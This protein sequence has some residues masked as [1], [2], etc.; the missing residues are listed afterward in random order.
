M[1]KTLITL[2]T[3]FTITSFAQVALI[4][5]DTLIDTF[6][7]IPRSFNG[8]S[9]YQNLSPNIHYRDG[10]R[11]VQELPNCEP[12]FEATN[13]EWTIENDIV[14]FTWDCEEIPPEPPQI[15]E[16]VTRRQFRIALILAGIELSDVEDALNNI[17]DP[18]E[19]AIALVEWNDAL[20]FK[21]NH[22]LIISFA[23]MFNLTQEDLDQLFL[24]AS[25]F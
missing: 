3:L 20:T 16:E 23:P 9:G 17:E 7:S 12:G 19:R 13:I 22:T 1:K 14:I 21:R 15:P 8:W 2:F 4:Q 5:D 24:T 10:F 18:V 6:T 11:Q 25:S